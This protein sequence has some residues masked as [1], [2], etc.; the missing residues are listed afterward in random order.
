[1]C[2]PIYASTRL[3]IYRGTS[4]HFNVNHDNGSNNAGRVGIGPSEPRSSRSR[5]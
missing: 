2:A 5:L 1:V 4:G 3:D